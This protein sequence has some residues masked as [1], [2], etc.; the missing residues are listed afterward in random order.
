MNAYKFLLGL[1]LTVALAAQVRGATVKATL[2]PAD[3]SL[4]DSTT[5]TVTVTGGDLP[6]LPRIPGLEIASGSESTISSFSLNGASLTSSTQTVVTY[7]IT[8][9]RAGVFTIPALESGDAKSEPLTLRVEAGSGGVTQAPSLP[10][11]SQQP[12]PNG[13]GPVVMPPPQQPST[14]QEASPVERGKYGDIQISLPKKQFYDGE[15]VPIEI[16]V[17]ISE[18][19]QS[20]IADLPQ[21]TSDGFTLNA[22]SQR[23]QQEDE[24]INGHPYRVLTWHSALTAV[25]PGEFTLNLTMPI[26]VVVRRQ[27]PDMNDPDAMQNFMQNAMAAM[28]GVKKEVNLTNTS[29][30]FKVLPLPVAGRPVNFGGAVGTFEAESSASPTHVNVGDPV[31]LTYAI[32]GHGNFDR[33]STELLGNDSNWRTY[34]PKVKFDAQDGVGYAGTKTFDQPV[35]PTNGSITE[36]PAL[37]FSYFNPER[38]AY[39]TCTAPPVPISVT[40]AP[41]AP[42]P[43]S[44]PT[45][46]TSVA[47]GTPPQTPT[48]AQSG[49]DLRINR[50]EAGSS[51]ATLEPIY[52]SPVFLAGQ[53]LPLVA[54]LGGLAFLRNRRSAAAPA[55][56]RLSAAQQAIRQQVA[57]MDAA[58]SDEQAGPFFV[59]ARNA[60]QQRY[61]SMWNMRPEA[62]TVNDLEARLGEAGA[63]A[64]TVFEMADQAMY[65]DLN[66]AAADLQQWRQVVVA[67]LETK[68]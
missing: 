66:I 2:D 42:A 16:R 60:L 68:K 39:E 24:E 4:G 25:K 14:A 20:G 46:S 56:A 19:V 57:A 41:V 45:P 7:S 67:E 18:E 13:P 37:S 63:N 5:L 53:A 36:V 26:T 28:Q 11:Q 17:L 31:T 65:S 6:Q 51:V 23:P 3:I 33:V 64:R 48:P 32:T 54:L 30:P 15:L 38:G 47:A 62:I 59:H 21:F 34:T 1:V 50:I 27:M 40:G 10:Q 12:Q 55:R 35:I 61:G 9:Q 52:L 58:M 29:E 22:L 8:P 49:P 43:A 44:T